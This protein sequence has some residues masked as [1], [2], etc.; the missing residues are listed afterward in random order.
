MAVFAIVA[1]PVVLFTF[2]GVNTLMSGLHSYGA[3]INYYLM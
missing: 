3:V 2:V 1:V